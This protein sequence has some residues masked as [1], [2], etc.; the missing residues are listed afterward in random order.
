M[1]TVVLR[2]WYCYYASVFTHVIACTGGLPP[3]R[4]QDSLVS[5]DDV[6]VDAPNDSEAPPKRFSTYVS[7]TPRGRHASNTSASVPLESVGESHLQDTQTGDSNP[8]VSV[9]DVTITRACTYGS[10][11]VGEIS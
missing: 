10:I 9:R 3:L 1:N 5:P 2:Q 7:H 8:G 4:G 6:F 11:L